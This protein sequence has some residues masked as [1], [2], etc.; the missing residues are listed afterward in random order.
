MGE[1][2]A[3]S[4]ENEANVNF[5]GQIEFLKKSSVILKKYL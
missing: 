2:L 5:T 3:L 4:G 1:I